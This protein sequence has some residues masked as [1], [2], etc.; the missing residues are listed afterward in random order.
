VNFKP[1]F[2]TA[3]KINTELSLLAFGIAGLLF[4]IWLLRKRKNSGI[5]WVAIVA[6]TFL[7]T[8]PIAAR[9]YLN[10]GGIY[11]V[12]V[13]VLDDR[14]FPTNEAKVTCSVPGEVK[15]VE[16]GWECDIPAKSKPADGKM[17]AFAAVD[18]AFLK[19]SVELELKDDYN[20]TVTIQLTQ[21]TDARATG[22]VTDENNHPLEGVHVSVVGYD[23]EAVMTAAAG[24]FSLPAHR[25]G[26]QQ[27][28]II[29][30][31][32]GYATNPPEWHQAG[33]FPITIVLHRQARLRQK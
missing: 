4:I 28:Q 5:S 21:S 13:V 15:K 19:G 6:I 14:Q 10:S 32:E 11:R 3:A 26:G 31:K 9:T 7:A 30:Y 25:A 2:E 24:G 17:Q 22:T 29:A 23:S 12:R 1:V 33:D 18:N 16:G 20:P 8:A 27:V